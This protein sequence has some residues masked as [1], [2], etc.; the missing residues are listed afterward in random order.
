MRTRA[1]RELGGSL[2]GSPMQDLTT[3]GFARRSASCLRSQPHP[4]SPRVWPT[5]SRT[6]STPRLCL[7]RPPSPCR[8]PAPSTWTGELTELAWERRPAGGISNGA[9]PAPTLGLIML[10]GTLSHDLQTWAHG[11]PVKVS[12][13]GDR[14][15]SPGAGRGPITQRR[16]ARR[17]QLAGHRPTRTPSSGHAYRSQPRWRHDFLL[18]G[19]WLREVRQS[20][21]R[22]LP[23]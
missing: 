4:L 21:D 14:P 7:D 6:R 22:S 5:G 17:L 20:A 18:T 23:P 3:A 10:R 2:P 12:R 15:A 11:S 13:G 9:V 16:P 8:R 19:T 1:N